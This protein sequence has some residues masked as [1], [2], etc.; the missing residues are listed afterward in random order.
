[1][2]GIDTNWCLGCD[3][4]YSTTEAEP[5]CSAECLRKHQQEAGPSYITSPY[6]TSVPPSPQ[7]IPVHHQN[8]RRRHYLSHTP[9]SSSFRSESFSELDLNTSYR[10]SPS[11]P[12]AASPSHNS[13]AS[14]HSSGSGSQTHAWVGQGAKG[15][16]AWAATIPYGQSPEEPSSSAISSPRH[17]RRSSTSSS[18]TPPSRPRTRASMNSSTHSG[19]QFLRPAALDL[20]A[21][22]PAPPRLDRQS[23]ISHIEHTTCRGTSVVSVSSPPTPTLHSKSMATVTPYTSLPSLARS[24]ASVS[25]TSIVTPGSLL[26]AGSRPVTPPESE[27]GDYADEFSVVDEVAEKRKEEESAVARV[28]GQKKNKAAGLFSNL[29]Q[30]IKAWAA[31]NEFADSQ[32]GVYSRQRT[33]SQQSQAPRNKTFAPSH[34]QQHTV[35]ECAPRQA[36]ETTRPSF[37]SRK[38][39]ERVS[40]LDDDELAYGF[41]GQGVTQSK[42]R[43]GRGLVDYKK[44]VLSEEQELDGRD[45][46]VAWR[47]EYKP[48]KEKCPPLQ[49][50]PFSLYGRL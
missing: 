26:H 36:Q 39:K 41:S 45:G 29:A 30:H 24:A 15:I 28:E 49:V 47:R 2:E 4:H 3:S 27:H 31:S 33:V 37:L 22:K 16:P 40:Y 19:S 44:V 23:N 8:P 10:P 7:P 5:Y 12:Y 18:L 50:V 11:Y 43:V 1:M 42:V 32:V 25:V 38:P 9:S 21:R 46:M 48:A 34:P 13:L 17:S 35:R 14:H 6:R 20:S